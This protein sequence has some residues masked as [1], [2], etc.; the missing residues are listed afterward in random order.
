MSCILHVRIWIIASGY[1]FSKI[2]S[3]V[4]T[5][6]SDDGIPGCVV[7]VADE[8]SAFLLPKILADTFSVQ[9][10][11]SWQQRDYTHGLHAI[12]QDEKSRKD[13]D[14]DTKHS[15]FTDL[16]MPALVDGINSVLSFDMRLPDGFSDFLR[17]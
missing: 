7:A 1:D 8:F 12:F 14:K 11:P 9:T 6:S 3:E 5:W 10:D 15:T 16:L 4:I 17:K 13:Y 2:Q